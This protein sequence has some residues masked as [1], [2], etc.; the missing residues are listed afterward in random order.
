MG[1]HGHACCFL[2]VS[3]PHAPVSPQCLLTCPD[4]G[5]AAV[6]TLPGVS[7]PAL[8]LQRAWTPRSARSWLPSW[9]TALVVSPP[10]HWRVCAPVRGAAPVAAVKFW[11]LFAACWGVFELLR[12]CIHQTHPCHAVL[13]VLSEGFCFNFLA[14]TLSIPLCAICILDVLFFI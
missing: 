10:R 3:R 12:A 9:C 11:R 5:D 4:M 13:H 1:G 6:T 2:P 8:W 7:C 14:G